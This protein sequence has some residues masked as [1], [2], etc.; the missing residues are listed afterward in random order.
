MVVALRPLSS[1]SSAESPLS[2]AALAL[3]LPA[4][5]VWVAVCLRLRRAFGIFNQ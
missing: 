3:A 1:R 2:K 4:A 5:A